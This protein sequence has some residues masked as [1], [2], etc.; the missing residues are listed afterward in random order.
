MLGFGFWVLVFRSFYLGCIPEMHQ[1]SATATGLGFSIGWILDKGHRSLR[2]EL[3]ER[4]EK[5]L[6]GRSCRKWGDKFDSLLLVSPSFDG[7]EGR[8]INLIHPK[9]SML[10]V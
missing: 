4:S 7:R 8:I 2:A 6:A 10:K 9:S 5:R 1:E 3:E